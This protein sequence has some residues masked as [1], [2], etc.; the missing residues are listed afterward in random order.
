VV[1]TEALELKTNLLPGAL[2]IAHHEHV[3]DGI[4]NGHTIQ[5]NYEG[6]DTLTIGTLVQ[7]HFHIQSRH[8]AQALWSAGYIDV[9]EIQTRALRHVGVRLEQPCAVRTERDFLAH[10][11]QL[12]DD[13]NY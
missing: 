13:R 5:I 9:L 10:D 7:Y 8:T 4:D 1:G 6:G 3:A 2:K 11:E 12:Q